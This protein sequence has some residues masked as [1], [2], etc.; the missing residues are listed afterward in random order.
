MGLDVAVL[1]GMVNHS[2]GPLANRHRRLLGSD[3]GVVLDGAFADQLWL[4]V[5]DVDLLDRES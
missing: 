3:E 2:G 5:W 1:I 4:I